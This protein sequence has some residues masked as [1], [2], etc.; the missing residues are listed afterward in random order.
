MMSFLTEYLS[1]DNCAN[2]P[3]DPGQHIVADQRQSNSFENITSGVDLVHAEAEVAS[4]NNDRAMIYHI[5][6]LPRHIIVS[7]MIDI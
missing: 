6:D 2:L 4:H 5:D 3:K 1:S 7:R